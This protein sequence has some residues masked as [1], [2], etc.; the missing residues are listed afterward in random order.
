MQNHNNYDSVASEILVQTQASWDGGP[1]PAYLPKTPELSVV[2]F[3]ME[4]HAELPWHTHQVLNAAYIISGSITIEKKDGTRKHFKAGEVI[5]ETINSIHRGL[6]G[7][8]HT[9]IVTFY[10]GLPGVPLSQ[11]QDQ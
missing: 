3:T 10:A 1:Y 6:V 4:P 11:P 2:R 8:Q 9:T 5:A 7:D